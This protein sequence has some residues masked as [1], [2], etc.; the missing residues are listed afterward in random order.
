MKARAMF[1]QALRRGPGNPTGANQHT[2]EQEKVGTV[3]NINDSSIAPQRPTGT[4]IDAG[5]RRLT[6]A[7]DVGDSRARMAYPR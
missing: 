4:A 7:A 6:K 1:D 5:L 2:E 3:D